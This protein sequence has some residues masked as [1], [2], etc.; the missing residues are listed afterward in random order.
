MGLDIFGKPATGLERV[1]ACRMLLVALG[2][3]QSKERR[4]TGRVLLV[5]YNGAL[6]GVL[7]V[8]PV[9]A[10]PPPPHANKIADIRLS[11]RTLPPG[12]GDNCLATAL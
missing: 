10:C 1:E 7:L 11:P 12:W 6:L 8:D 3:G 2:L 5:A 9:S 4:G